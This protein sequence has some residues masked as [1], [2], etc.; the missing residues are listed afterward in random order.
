MKSFLSRGW[1]IT[2]VVFLVLLIQVI[3]IMAQG[4]T[5][6]GSFSD[7]AGKA[8][9]VDPQGADDETSPSRA[10]ITEFRADA[11]SSG[12]YLLMAWDDTGF[13]GGQSTTAGITLQTAG[14]AYYRI[15]A[16]AQGNPGSVP[17]S[18]LDINS[19]TN[20][21]CQNQTDVCTGSGCSGA[22]AGSGTSWVDPFSGRTGPGCN[23]TNCGTQDTAVELYIPW[24]YFGGA[25]GNGQFVFLQLGS[26][27]SGPA[28]AS[29]DNTGP[30]GV[31][32]RNHNGT[33]Q[34]YRSTPTDVTLKSF[35]ASSARMN[36]AGVAGASG[37]IILFCA[38]IGACLR[39]LRVP[40]GKD[41]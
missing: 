37:L 4:I 23:G 17:L 39:W 6:D 7:W 25:P 21:T 41:A 2:F 19:C 33:F 5:I 12:L 14:N 20:A 40:G 10:D 24:S 26:Y 29:K 11:S 31:A 38:G 30:N 28:Q 1:A 9:M 27:P 13:A 15:Y 35:A 3:P 18:S 32:C 22:Q 16:T 8:A 34:C 36:P